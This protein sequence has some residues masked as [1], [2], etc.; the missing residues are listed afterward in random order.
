M[1][2]LAVA[3][4]WVAFDPQFRMMRPWS[5][6]AFVCCVLGFVVTLC[7]V[8]VAMMREFVDTHVHDERRADESG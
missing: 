8:M 2:A 5:I 6:V 3:T 4:G 7:R 1:F